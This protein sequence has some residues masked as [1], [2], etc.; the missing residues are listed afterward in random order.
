MRCWNFGI[1][2]FGLFDVRRPNRRKC[3]RTVRSTYPT[4]TRDTISSTESKDNSL[5]REPRACR[6]KT[7]RISQAPCLLYT[8]LLDGLLSYVTRQ[9]PY[10]RPELTRPKGFRTARPAPEERFNEDLTLKRSRIATTARGIFRH[11]RMSCS[12]TA[13]PTLAR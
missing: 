7:F 11:V 13:R 9:A 6:S 1:K 5:C 4:V 12:C 2:E 10:P 8:V 3:T